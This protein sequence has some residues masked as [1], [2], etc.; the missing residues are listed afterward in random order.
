MLLQILRALCKALEGAGS[1][2]KCL[3]ALVRATGVLGR[4]AYGFRTEIHFTDEQ[5]VYFCETVG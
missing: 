4:F 5:D 3:A 1:I 2:W